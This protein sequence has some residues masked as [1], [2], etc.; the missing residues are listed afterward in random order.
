MLSESLL[1]LIL[2]PGKSTL[3]KGKLPSDNTQ[4]WSDHL[5]KFLGSD[6]EKWANLKLNYLMLRPL[7]TS[8]P[9]KNFSMFIMDDKK[10]MDFHNL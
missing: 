1:G 10:T 6:M 3:L 5:T 9:K 8:Y 7:F 2:T 4:N